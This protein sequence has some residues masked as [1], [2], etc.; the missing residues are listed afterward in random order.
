[1]TYEE[2]GTE[3]R[4]YGIVMEPVASSS[5]LDYL[6]QASDTALRP[7]QIQETLG[8]AFGCLASSLAYMHEVSVAGT[9]VSKYSFKGRRDCSDR[10]CHPPAIQA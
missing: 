10:G 5:L 8:E 1:M 6:L 3:H 4:R 7:P 2:L 9:S